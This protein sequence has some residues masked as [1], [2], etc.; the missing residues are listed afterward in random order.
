[1]RYLISGTD[2]SSPFLLLQ[3]TDAHEGILVFHRQDPCISLNP[4]V[5]KTCIDYLAPK[6]KEIRL[7]EGDK[8]L[9]EEVAQYRRS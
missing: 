7:K 9:P 6:R 8:L 4:A 1:M 3:V 5:V 2:A